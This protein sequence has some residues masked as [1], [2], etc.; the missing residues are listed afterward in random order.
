MSKNITIQDLVSIQ[1]EVENF[2]RLN[3]CIYE[4][5]ILYEPIEFLVNTLKSL[6]SEFKETIPNEKLLQIISVPSIKK[7]IIEN[8]SINFNI[9]LNIKNLINLISE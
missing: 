3:L 6:Y 4:C 9:F 5:K 8:L 7:D 1:K 2:L